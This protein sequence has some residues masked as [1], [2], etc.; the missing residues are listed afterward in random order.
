VECVGGMN[1]FWD[2]RQR[3]RPGVVPGWG[4]SWWFAELGVTRADRKA[5]PQDQ[6]L[7]LLGHYWRAV[8]EGWRPDVPR[9]EWVGPYHPFKN[10][11][12]AR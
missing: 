9:S 11:D 2:D 5:M 1:E 6:W 3:L 7:T 10:D 8:R 4:M 12:S